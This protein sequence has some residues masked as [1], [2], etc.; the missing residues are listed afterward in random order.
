MPKE[1]DTAAAELDAAA[2]ELDARPGNAPIAEEGNQAAAPIAE[3]EDAAAAGLDA[4]AAELDAAAAEEA[5][6]PDG[7]AAAEEEEPLGVGW[8]VDAVAPEPDWRRRFEAT[9]SSCS[10]ILRLAAH[11]SRARQRR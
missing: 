8:R 5:A 1:E 7:N 10:M 9:F 3:E 4:A 6:A 11:R 2:A